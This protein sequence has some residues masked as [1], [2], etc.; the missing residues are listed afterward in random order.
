MEIKVCP[1][2]VFAPLAFDQRLLQ[3]IVR[4]SARVAWTVD[5]YL[6]AMLRSARLA[7][8]A[9]QLPGIVPQEFSVPGFAPQ[10]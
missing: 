8:C 1:T 10:E 6:R 7:V 9:L 3:Q 2:R 4:F 5:V